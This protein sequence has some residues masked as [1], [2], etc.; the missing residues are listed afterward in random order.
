MPI[1]VPLVDTAG[2][3]ITNFLLLGSDTA[4]PLNS[5]RTDVIMVVSVNQTEGAVALLSIPRDLYVY[6]PSAGMQRINTV[7]AQGEM[8]QEGGGPELLAETIRA[9]LGLNIDHYARVDF[10]DFKQIID[11][12]GGVDISVDCAIQDWRLREPN[13]DPTIEENWVKYTLPIGVHHLDGDLALWYVRSRRTSSDF[14]RG[15]RQQEVMRALWRHVRAMGLLNQLPDI[16]T[17][18]LEIVDTDVPLA[19][20]LG[21]LPLAATLKPDRVSSYVFRLNHEVVGWNAPD[22]AQVLLPQQQAVAEL[23]QHFLTPPTYL[24][25]NANPVRVRI[26]NAS[27]RADLAVVA[28]DRLTWKGFQVEIVSSGAGQYRQ[29]VTI[30]DY[31]GRR[32]GSEL[33]TLK[34]I[35]RVGDSGVIT[36]PDADRQYD[37]EVIL[38]SSYNACNR[39]VLPPVDESVDT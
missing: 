14:D 3:G 11:S 13:L 27:G 4:N 15:Q 26:I 7:Y 19:D 31:T 8:M 35:L 18:L 2:M 9:N 23:I 20:M 22:G 21:L 38:G 32:K 24:Q 12:V 6:V 39:D 1:P 29:T 30:H 28:A 5:G 34:S 25:L 36:T 10:V 16:W 37:Y 33:K 17:Q